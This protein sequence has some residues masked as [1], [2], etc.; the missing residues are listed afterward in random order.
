[1]APLIPAKG[2]VMKNTIQKMFATATANVNNTRT[3][4]KTTIAIASKV[5]ENSGR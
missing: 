4:V 3:V 1:M 5:S 2:D